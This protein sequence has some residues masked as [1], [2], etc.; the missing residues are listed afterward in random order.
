[1]RDNG[2][3]G[4]MA[5]RS[6]R[7]LGMGALVAWGAATAAAQTCTTQAKL[8]DD[9]RS[10]LADTALSIAMD[11]KSNNAER[12]RQESIGS[13][14]SNFDQTAYLLRTTSEKIAADSLAVTQLYLLDASKVAAGASG[15]DFACPLTGT[16]SEADFNF[17]ALPPAVYAFAMVEGSGPRPWLVSLLLQQDGSAWKLAGLYTHARI[18]AGKN[19]LSYWSAAREAAKAKQLWRAWILYAE[20]DALLSPAPFLDTTHL[21]KLRSEQRDAAPPELADGIS[22][23][24]PLVLKNA[25]GENVAFTALSPDVSED[26]TKLRLALHYRGEPVTDAV[27][28][29]ARNLAAAQTL[30]D[31]H[32]ELRQGIDSVFVFAD[33]AGQPP[34]ANEIPLTEI[35]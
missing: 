29:R 26:G 6:L 11:V 14:A 32:K 31:A 33:I 15:V 22:A 5:G 23:Q 30:L 2:T 9:L 19:G 13:L 7:L 27:V 21:D 16:S 25:K 35:P 34:F 17:G 4:R 8:T 12:I 28:G 18:A 24:T 10:N 20:A 3:N 1:M